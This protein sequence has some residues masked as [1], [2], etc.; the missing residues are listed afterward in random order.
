[1]ASPDRGFIALTTDLEL[2]QISRHKRVGRRSKS[3]NAGA[4]VEVGKLSDS[5]TLRATQPIASAGVADADEG[6]EAVAMESDLQDRVLTTQSLE[7]I[8]N[9]DDAL[10]LD[11]KMDALADL[12]L[13]TNLAGTAAG[14]GGEGA[15]D[16][17]RY[18][19]ALTNGGAAGKHADGDDSIDSVDG[20][21]V[22]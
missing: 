12:I 1:M 15:K 4:A 11:Q 3:R 22:D 8:F 9:G 21:N 14:L 16:D 10:T 20:M 5:Y 13:G 18:L 6:V 17:D 19:T 7:L 2:V